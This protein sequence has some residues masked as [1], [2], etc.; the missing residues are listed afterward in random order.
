MAS[1]PLHTDPPP[2]RSAYPSQIPSPWARLLQGLEGRTDPFAPGPSPAGMAQLDQPASGSL[3]LLRH[4]L[5]ALTS[6]RGSTAQ[7]PTSLRVRLQLRRKPGPKFLAIL[8][9]QS[10]C[11]TT[12]LRG[13]GPPHLAL[14]TR[15][16]AESFKSAVPS[17]GS[18]QD[19]VLPTGQRTQ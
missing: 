8:E 19:H 3:N 4:Q 16:N 11:F 9:F 18:G 14:L 13:T 17:R 5:L 15:P 7:L 10:C 12:D 1:R 2:A 6:V